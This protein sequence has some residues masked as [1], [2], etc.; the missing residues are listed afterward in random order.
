MLRA[1]LIAVFVVLGWIVLR[2]TAT[3]L[4]P[5]L[6]AIGI[7]YMLNPVLDRLVHRGV[8][9]M[10]GA[11]VLLVGL[12]SMLVGGVTIVAPKVANQLRSS[13]TIRRG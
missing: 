3:V 13:F 4:A 6:A 1:L 10:L 5:I 12:V 2:Y 11:A 9:R 8:P 7:A